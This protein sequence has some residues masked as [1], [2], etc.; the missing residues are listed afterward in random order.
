[1]IGYI[2]PRGLPQ[3]SN[4]CQEIVLPNF[5]NSPMVDN[6]RIDIWLIDVSYP[7]RIIKYP[8]ESDYSQTITRA[9]YEQS[10]LWVEYFSKRPKS[11]KTDK[12]IE[13]HKAKMEYIAENF[14]DELL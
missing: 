8:Y 12:K 3:L 2:T 4:L 10:E 13:K 11:K 6:T 7:F 5:S 14:P 1:M 9:Q